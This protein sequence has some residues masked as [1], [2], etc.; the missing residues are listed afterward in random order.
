MH[1][2]LKKEKKKKKK[3][4]YFCSLQDHVTQ[5]CK[6][7]PRLLQMHVKSQYLIPLLFNQ[8]TLK[9]DSV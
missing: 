5:C 6:L 9:I 8:D 7:K 2:S 4:D 1:I 3:I